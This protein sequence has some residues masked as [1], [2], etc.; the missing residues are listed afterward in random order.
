M[1]DGILF[2]LGLSSRQVDE[3]K[4][5]FAFSADAAI[6]MRMDPTTG[7]SGAEVVN[8]YP[9]ERLKELF[10]IY[11]EERMAGPIARRISFAR[12]RSAITTTGELAEIVRRVVGGKFLLKSL[13]RVFQ[14]I[15]IEVNDELGMLSRALE[16]VVPA[17]APGGRVVVISYNSLEDRIVKQWIKARAA[18]G[19][20]IALTKKVVIPGDDEQAVNRRSRSAK[21]RAAERVGASG[22]MGEAGKVGS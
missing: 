10:K 3:P 17:L 4:R 1:A 5:G 14:A 20:L 21:L 7:V 13:A 6:D 15:R 2:D 19:E 16:Q 22:E 11:G 18:A 8:T 9:V 12:E